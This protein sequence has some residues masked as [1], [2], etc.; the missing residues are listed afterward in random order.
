MRKK[1]IRRCA[2]PVCNNTFIVIDS[3]GLENCIAA[4]N[5]KTQPSKDGT[6]SGEKQYEKLDHVAAGVDAEHGS[7]I[8]CL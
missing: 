8:T 1:H 5:A 4:M 3:K 6:G 7:T 2:N